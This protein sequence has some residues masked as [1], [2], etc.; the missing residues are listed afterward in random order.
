MKEWCI[1]HPWMTF[2]IIL[3]LIDSIDNIIKYFTGYKVIVDK[4]DKAE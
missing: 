2:F 1:N 3:S 4:E